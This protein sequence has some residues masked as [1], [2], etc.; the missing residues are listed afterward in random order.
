MNREI[1]FRAW[2]GHSK[3]MWDNDEIIIWNGSVYINHK[4]KLKPKTYGSLSSESSLMQYVGLKDKNGVE[5]YT[6]D[7]VKSWNGV[8][9]TPE[10]FVIIW[11]NFYKGFS[12]MVDDESTFNSEN[13][14]VVGNIYEN[15]EIIMNYRKKELRSKERELQKYREQ[16]AKKK[17]DLVNHP[18]HYNQ[19]SQEVI[20]TIEEVTVNMPVTVAYHVGNAVKYLFRAPFKGKLKQDIEKAVWYL[21]R[22]VSKL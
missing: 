16:I 8:N 4:K 13:C 9:D 14:E 5:V 11:S 6:G 21:E 17:E 3:K 1:K 19:Y 10:L 18:A 2:D 20:D 22:A 12:P 7:I 15:R